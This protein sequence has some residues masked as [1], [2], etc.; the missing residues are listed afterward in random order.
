[1]HKTKLGLDDNS[2]DLDEVKVALDRWQEGFVPIA[3]EKMSEAMAE[4][5]DSL[6]LADYQELL[7]QA[8]ITTDV[9]RR[10]SVRHSESFI[11]DQN[12][13]SGQGFNT[14]DLALQIKEFNQIIQEIAVL[15]MRLL[16]KKATTSVAKN[17]ADCVKQKYGLEIDQTH[18]CSRLIQENIQKS[19]D[20][21]RVD[22]GPIE[23]GL[24]SSSGQ[25]NS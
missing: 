1:M 10:N 22:D 21:H 18:L 13:E 23:E 8:K 15:E 12:R 5:I 11:V 20:L 24:K 4:F 2:D 16:F 6:A 17:F 3:H 7:D 14:E 19:L 25:Y 9:N